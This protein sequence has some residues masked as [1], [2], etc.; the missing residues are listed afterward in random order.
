VNQVEK[1]PV[2]QEDA[3]LNPYIEDVYQ[4]FE[5]YKKARKEIEDAEGSLLN[6]AEGH[7]YYGINF[8]KEKNTAGLTGNGRLPL[9]TFFSPAILTGGTERRTNWKET[10]KETGKYFFLT[11]NIKKLLYTAA[12]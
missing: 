11:K 12:G 2:I 6:F 7:Y 8:N 5:R 1:L 10:I 4:R 3:W 9:T